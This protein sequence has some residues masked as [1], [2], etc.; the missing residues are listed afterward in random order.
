MVV[1]QST[2]ALNVVENY[3]K[4]SKYIINGPAAVKYKRLLFGG[5]IFFMS[6]PSYS[7]NNLE[8]SYSCFYVML[9]LKEKGKISFFI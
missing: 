3:R 8:K 1:Y 9:L 7:S 5:G 6:K 2:S 4:Y